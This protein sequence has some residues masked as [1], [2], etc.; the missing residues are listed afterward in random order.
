M[1]RIETMSCQAPQI[2][3][4]KTRLRVKDKTGLSKA[5]PLFRFARMR[6]TW[7]AGGT[8]RMQKGAVAIA[9]DSD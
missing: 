4:R 6:V 3:I 7:S 9:K 1:G 8:S 5:F 2:T